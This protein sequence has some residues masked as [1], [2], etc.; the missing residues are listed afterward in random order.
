MLTLPQKRGHSPF[1]RSTLRAVPA[2]GGC[3]LFCSAALFALC[4]PALGPAE[5]VA[6]TARWD[7]SQQRYVLMLP[8]G[9]KPGQAHDL[10][11]ALHG[12]GSDRWQFVRSPRDECRAARDVAAE[13]G[14]IYVSPDYRA[15]TSWMGPA[16]EADVVQI[17]AELRAKYSIGRVILC[18]GSMGA[19]S[20]LTFA[21]LHPEL[22]DGVAAMNGHASHVEYQGFQD[23]IRQSFGGTK[24]EKPEEY[25][26]RSAEFAAERLRMPIA[27]SVSD[28]DRSV[29]PASAIRL[30]E[31]LKSLGRD[32]LL[33]RRP[34]AGHQT[35]YEDSRAVVEWAVG[36]AKAREK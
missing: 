15:K 11:V 14:M 24:L 13:H 2:N 34:N 10:L 27:M 21:G 16:A 9:F 5:D 20:A 29:P 1:V 19:T 22:V 7:G 25:R 36:K 33:I 28:N 6:F 32:V 4:A 30:A 12:H 35:S 23:A 17:L 8:D 26:R 31:K 3:P 18:G